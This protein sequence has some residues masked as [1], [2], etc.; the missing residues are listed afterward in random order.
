M[1]RKLIVM[2]ALLP[3][4]SAAQVKIS[5][6]SGS[7]D[8]SS[9]LEIES[10]DKGFLPPRMTIVQRNQIVNPSNGLVVFNTT[11]GCL[12][13]RQNGAWYELCGNLAAAVVSS[14]DCGGITHTGNL[15]SGV[16]ADGVSSTVS[17]AGG[18]GEAYSGQAVSSTGV[19]G[20]T[21]TLAPGTLNTGDGTLT[22]LIEG[23]PSAA[24]TASFV[25][26]V[27]GQTCT[28]QRTVEFVCGATS[29]SFTYKGQS[30][31]YG[32]VASG[33]NRCWLDRNLGAT[34]VATSGTDVN[35]YGDLFQWG[36]GDDGHQNRNSSTVSTQSSSPT[37]GSSFITTHTNW[38]NGPNPDDFW[39]GESGVNN[40]CPDGWRLPTEAE[41]NV[42]VTSWGVNANA[43]GAYASPLRLPA[44]GRRNI[45]T[46]ALLDAGTRGR[47]HSGTVSGTDIQNLNFD[48]VA[49]SPGPNSRANGF[50][51]RCIKD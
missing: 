28:L 50:S 35:S 47:Y 12:N 33:G 2:L 13:Y 32:V 38:Y 15:T 30:V 43:A 17:Y 25:L 21:A 19:T 42:E 41:W 6:G 26:N 4:L 39:Q 7:P 29:V 36:R 23:T 22:Y 11:S 40:P 37:P 44:A 10:V 3:F 16:A 18:N 9:M 27:G 14:L 5:S 46:G 20:L 1:M 51:V 48:A 31:T 8:E 34:Q 45:S 24:G 49:A